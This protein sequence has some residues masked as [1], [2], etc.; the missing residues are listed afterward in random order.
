[1]LLTVAEL[2][3]AARHDVT[4][5]VLIRWDRGGWRQSRASRQCAVDVHPSDH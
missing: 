4:D 1:M 2:F 3:V 5:Y